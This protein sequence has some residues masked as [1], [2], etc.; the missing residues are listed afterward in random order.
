MLQYWIAEG[1]KCFKF[2]PFDGPLD[3]AKCFNTGPL[4][5][6]AK[7][8]NYPGLNTASPRDAKAGGVC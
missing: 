2:G 7:C 1:A 4:N 8:S 5:D 3:G 6:G